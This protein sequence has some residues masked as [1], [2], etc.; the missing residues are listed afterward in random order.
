[1][2]K[3]NKIIDDNLSKDFS[4]INEQIDYSRFTYDKRKRFKL[5][6]VLVPSISLFLVIPICLMLV[7]LLSAIHVKSTA[8]VMKASYSINEIKKIESES[9][10]SI[11][12][13]TYP[14]ISEEKKNYAVDQE[15]I[16]ALNNFSQ[17]IN[18]T[19][20][21]SSSNVVY[22]PLS[23]YTL[24]DLCSSL[25]NDKETLDQFNG[26]LGES[27]LRNSNYKNMYKNN[28]WC[29]STGTTQMYNG[30]FV[31]NQSTV[32]S[33]ILDQLTSKYVEAFSLD[34]QKDDDISRMLSWIDQKIDEKNF[35]NKNDLAIDEETILFLFS[36]L[37]YKNNWYTKFIK[38]NSYKDD[39]YGNDHT[40]L[41]TYMNHK[42]YTNKIYDYKTY[43]TIRDY[44]QN[45]YSIKYIFPKNLEDNIHDLI[46]DRNIFI[47]DETYVY[48]YTDDF[49]NDQTSIIINLS[50][51][52]FQ[53]NTL[54]DFSSSLKSL[55]LDKAFKRDGK[56][57]NY[58][59]T[60]LQ[61]YESAYLKYVKQKNTISF[62]EDG[63]EA[64]TVS[65]ASIGKATSSAIIQDTLYVKLNQPF[66][67]IIEDSN[68]LPLYVGSVNQL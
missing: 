8:K 24:L 18:S 61:E 13:V 20:D 14:E 48:T 31:S 53:A 63:T 67:Y 47:D 45:D 36:T 19:I 29:T 41:V 46:E 2:K 54:I 26:L 64:K 33:S 43:Y 60:S 57:F 23:L 42:Y 7:P 56:S 32:N 65:F 25:S 66:I 3:I 49:G 21:F 44:Y 22:S 11:N 40:S 34:F 51:P 35:I 27:E 52:S 6:Y 30:L 10:K 9:F 17:K 1:M 5:R 50:V 16:D 4:S 12:T 28:Y 15:Y 55:G 38:E 59:F 39:F 62:D 58:A 37:Y 68:G